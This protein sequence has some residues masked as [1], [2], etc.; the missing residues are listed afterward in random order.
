M[1]RSLFFMYITF[2]N[3]GGTLTH[4]VN[5]CKVYDC[6]YNALWYNNKSEGLEAISMEELNKIRAR[7]EIPEA[8][9]WAVE[10][11]YTSE[12]LWEADLQAVAA[13]EKEL[14]AFAGRKDPL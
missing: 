2:F 5:F 10:D 3:I 1:P 6:I 8:D 4:S 13:K 14:I 9:K 12:E 7:V 11:L